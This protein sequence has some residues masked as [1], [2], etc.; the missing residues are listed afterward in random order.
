MCDPKCINTLKIEQFKTYI[1]MS[2][3]ILDCTFQ[4]IYSKSRN[5]SWNI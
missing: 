5:T 4:K 3:Y 2:W 1:W